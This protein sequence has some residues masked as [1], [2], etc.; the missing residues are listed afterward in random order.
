M[1][2]LDKK[3]IRIAGIHIAGPNS[4]KT[5]M[6]LLSNN[7]L[8]QPIRVAG[9]FGRI[10]N[11]GRHLSDDRLIEI[12]K[13]HAPLSGVFVDVPLTLPPCMACTRPHCPGVTRC[14]DVSVNY[15]LALAE[16]LTPRRQRRHRPVNPQSQRLWD[17][18]HTSQRSGP[19]HEPTYNP[20]IA[21]LITR[22]KTLQ[23]RL[24]LVL[25]SITVSE[26]NI[27][28]ALELLA[29]SF[30][31]DLSLAREYRSFSVGIERRHA[32][33]EILMDEGWLS[34][35]TSPDMVD[36]ISSSVEIFHSF[37]AAFIGCMAQSFLSSQIPQEYDASLGWVYL[38]SLQV[39]AQP[40]PAPDPSGTDHSDESIK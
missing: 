11:Y 34:D 3:P 37:L 22:A 27:P 6:S 40:I 12:M 17:I 20:N 9:I 39:E 28:L 14:E 26:T 7:P 32:W 1:Q 2:D 35:E 5:A 4:G 8:E 25:P 10:G 36:E 15:M 31:S 16:K 29:E 18:Y 13:R 23:R 33:L 21:P 19:A 30:G 24:K 38:P